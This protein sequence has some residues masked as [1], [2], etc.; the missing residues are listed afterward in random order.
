MI[1]LTDAAIGNWLS[2][3][4]QYNVYQC[5]KWQRWTE[6]CNWYNQT[7]RNVL[8]WYMNHQSD[9]VD[10]ILC[11]NKLSLSCSW[12]MFVYKSFII[13]VLVAERGTKNYIIHLAGSSGLLVKSWL[14]IKRLQVQAPLG[15]G[16]FRL[17]VYSALPSKMR[18]CS[19]LHPS[20]GM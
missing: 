18:R 6:T 14:A 3:Y 13:T 8:Q 11:L 2:L 10:H 1:Q 9:T 5:D 7:T 20:E 19:S 4:K 17:W 16:F 12:C 15:T